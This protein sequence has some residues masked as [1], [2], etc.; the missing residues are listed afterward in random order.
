MSQQRAFDSVLGNSA[1]EI[2]M[3]DLWLGP[4]PDALV[5]E[6]EQ[7]TAEDLAA[8]IARTFDPER[9]IVTTLVPE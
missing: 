5:R 1:L 2:G 4:D 9:M 3:R 7:L 8:L 6:A